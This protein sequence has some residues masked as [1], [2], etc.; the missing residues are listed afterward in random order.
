MLQTDR[1]RIIPTR[2]LF[3]LGSTG[4][5]IAAAASIPIGIFLS[6]LLIG[7]GG[8]DLA[9]GFLVFGLLSIGIFLCS[10]GSYGFWRDYRLKIAAVALGTQIAAS[11]FLVVSSLEARV[12]CDEPGDCYRGF[13][14]SA[15][16]V[17]GFLVLGLSS[18]IEG[19]GIVAVGS[20]TRHT[21]TA[22][23]A[24][25]LL[26]VAGAILMSLLL[27]IYG[28]FFVLAAAHLVS[29]IVVDS[30]PDPPRGEMD[31]PFRRP[32]ETSRAL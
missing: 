13:G 27:V 25:V 4:H 30:V 15:L 8:Y 6:F 9:R 5:F 12:A 16:F 21:L 3:R 11:L 17:V 20:F 14:A 29:G 26:I 2:W 31:G 23:A 28:A 7:G 19:V 32:P 10:F 1:P 22:C 18:I 24:G